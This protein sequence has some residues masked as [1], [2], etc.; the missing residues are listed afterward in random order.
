MPPLNHSILEAALVGLQSQKTRIDAQI[1]EVRSMLPSGLAKTSE[2]APRKRRAFSAA[3][4]LKMK[5]AQQARWAKI[6]GQSKPATAKVAKPK[7]KLSEA[8]KAA[9]VAALKKRWAAKKAETAKPAAAKKQM[10]AAKAPEA[11]MTP[12]AQ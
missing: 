7:R 2:A 4:R 10:V 9:I 6:R 11:A 1:A 12:A 3:T 5:A 8:G